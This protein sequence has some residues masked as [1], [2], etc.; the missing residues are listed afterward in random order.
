[1]RPMRLDVRAFALT[2]A[3]VWGAGLFA[4]TWWVIAFDGA[5]GD[6]TLVGRLYRGYRLSPAGSVIGLLWA[7]PDGLLF[8]ALFAW[9]YN[10]IAGRL[11]HEPRGD[12]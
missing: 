8:G 1:M 12:G 2:S 7:L 3:L 5:S 4:F 9:L 10:S 6:P 11:S